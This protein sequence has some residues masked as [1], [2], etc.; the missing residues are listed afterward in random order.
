[1]AMALTFEAR[2]VPLRTDEHGVVRVV[3]SR[4]TLDTLV[5]AFNRSST[6][7]QVVQSFPTLKVADVY[8]IFAYYLDHREE[9]DA[10]IREQEQAAAEVRKLVE[11]QPG[12]WEFRE[13]LLERKR[14]YLQSR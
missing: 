10:Y 8:A 1:M 9:V 11:S 5:S 7:E 2:P 3:G 14:A 12:Y 4:I 13:R 6:P